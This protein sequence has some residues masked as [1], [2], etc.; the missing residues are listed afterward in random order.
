MN[1]KYIKNEISNNFM[2]VN[3]LPKGSRIWNFIIKCRPLVADYLSWDVHEGSSCLF[4]E[5]SWGGYPSIDRLISI[6]S[7]KDW[8]KLYWGIYIKDY[9]VHSDQDPLGWHWKTFEGLPLPHNELDLLWKTI[10][11][12]QPF[13][14]KG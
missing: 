10:K 6:Q 13:F 11:N 14:R 4:W 3:R 12:R 7:T 2:T 1:A 5:D 9:V 8:L